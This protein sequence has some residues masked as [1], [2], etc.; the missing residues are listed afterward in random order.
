MINAKL[1][2]VIIPVVLIPL[3]ILLLWLA[4]NYVSFQDG[5]IS[6]EKV[7]TRVEG[8]A[9][10][11]TDL[12]NHDL[13]LNGPLLHQ[14][15]FSEDAVILSSDEVLQD[16]KRVTRMRVEADRLGVAPTEEEIQARKDSLI[17]AAVGEE[18]IK[19]QISLYGWNLND[20]SR[21]VE[22]EILTEKV[23][24][25][26][27][28][29]REAEFV[30]MRFD[31]LVHS[32]QNLERLTPIAKKH[33]EGIEA[34]FAAGGSTKKLAESLQ[35]DKKVLTDFTANSIQYTTLSSD[36]AER[37]SQR[38]RKNSDSGT[39]EVIESEGGLLPTVVPT[40]EPLA[41]DKHILEMKVPT[42]AEIWCDGP[43]CYLIRVAAGSDGKYASLDDWFKAQ[44]L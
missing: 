25:A 26:V 17:K 18:N 13:L 44:G 12:D 4:W 7:L 22:I 6:L 37:A 8:E 35:K 32:E 39:P 34:K 24:D 27:T 19:H 36:S 11:Q 31:V 9:I 10:T 5:S 41:V 38:I 21:N 15:S 2:K 3:V 33:L 20:W 28:F 29:W 42:K 30:A 14:K 1:L 16:L 40:R 43:A 23:T